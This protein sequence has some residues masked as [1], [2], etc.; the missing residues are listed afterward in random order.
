MECSRDG[1]SFLRAYKE[2]MSVVSGHV[3]VLSPLVSAVFGITKL[4]P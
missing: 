4:L 1:G 3:S 2:F